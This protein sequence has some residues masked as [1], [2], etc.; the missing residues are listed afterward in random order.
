[1]NARWGW[2]LGQAAAWIVTVA[3]VAWLSSWFG[4]AFMGIDSLWRLG[5]F[6]AFGLVVM[7]PLLWLVHPLE[8]RRGRGPSHTV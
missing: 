7:T 2:A 3:I 6:A 1:M 5:E 4:H 8:M